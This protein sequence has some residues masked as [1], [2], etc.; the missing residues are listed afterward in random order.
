MAGPRADD[1]RVV[2][3]EYILKSPVLTAA[4]RANALHFIDTTSPTADAMTPEQFLLCALRLAA[5]AD[6]GHDVL[7]AG[8]EAW[9]PGARL[10]VRMIWFQ[11]TWVIARTDS[12]HA[13]ILGARVL[14]IEGKTSQAVFRKA[15][16]L[17][18]GTDAY[19]RWNI[20]GLLES[21]G[22]LHALGVAPQSDR[23]ELDLQLPD[24]HRAK[25]TLHFVPRSEVPGGQP[26]RRVWSPAPWPGESDKGWSAVNPH[27]TP[28]YLQEGERSFRVVRIPQFD[29]VY[30]QMRTHLDTPQETIE[31][32]RRRADEAIGQYHPRNLI[33]DLRFDS[34]GNTE[35]TRDWQ[36]TL[37]QRVPGRLYALVSSYT[38][39][40]GI[41]A[42]AALKH[43]AG[44][45][46]RIVGDRVGDRLRWWSEGHDVC[47]PNSHYCMHL[48]SGLWDLVHGCA[49]QPG[50][51]GD[52]YDVHI[53]G[54][55]PDLYAPLT[56]DD[57][58]TGRDPGLEAIGR[59][60]EK[61]DR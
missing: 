50:C 39:S 8:D 14:R 61:R 54:L 45:R 12:A 51:Y 36:R 3:E 43:D 17:F 26:P 27:P 25:R 35:L 57:W 9:F 7:N 53:G 2:R 20:E 48:T 28:L 58:L 32:F 31:D 24:G 41:V 16:D 19:R 30:L 38:F 29:A 46:A 59:D 6:N 15:R 52:R 5:S 33:F 22:V 49:G 37:P 34:G 56:A 44:S 10:P 23:L 1:L 42:A 47:M 40:A 18:G 4:A 55:G 21:A 60:L 11:D 13:D